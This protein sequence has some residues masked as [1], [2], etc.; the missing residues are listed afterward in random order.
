MGTYCTHCEKKKTVSN[1]RANCKV[2]LHIRE[3][4][5]YVTAHKC[6]HC[7]LWWIDEQNIEYDTAAYAHK[8]YRKD[9]PQTDKRV[10]EEHE[11]LTNA[12]RW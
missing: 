7:G 2:G 4:G 9:N 8:K 11:R 5:I 6:Q 12:I 1:T 10:E 3:L